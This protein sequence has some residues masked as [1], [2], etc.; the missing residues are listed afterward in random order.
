M[1]PCSSRIDCKKDLE[2]VEVIVLR[3]SE[4]VKK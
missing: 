3:K 4:S 1:T 2:K